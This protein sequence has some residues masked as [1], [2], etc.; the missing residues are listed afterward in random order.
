MEGGQDEKMLPVSMARE[1]MSP[2]SMAGAI[3]TFSKATIMW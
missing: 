3:V 2:A 1:S